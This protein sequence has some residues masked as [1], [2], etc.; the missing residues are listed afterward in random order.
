MEIIVKNNIKEIYN[1][2]IDKARD[3]FYASHYEEACCMVS[4]G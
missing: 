2:R 3:K 1:F 4:A